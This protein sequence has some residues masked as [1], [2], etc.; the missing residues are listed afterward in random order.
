MSDVS[1]TYTPTEPFV[2]IKQTSVVLAIANALL[3]L[4]QIVAA[5]FS[6]S[7]AL[8][9]DAMHT[10]SDLIF[11]IITYFA[12]MYGSQPPDSTQPY[13]YRRIETMTAILLSFILLGLG[14]GILYTTWMQL[15]AP[16]DV[17]SDYVVFAALASIITNEALYRYAA[18][19]AELI[20]SQLLLASATHQRT[21][22][23]SSVVV[24]LTAALDI[25]G[26]SLNMD[27]YGALFIGCM[28]V[29]MGFSI[30]IEG[31]RELM[32][33]GIDAE[34]INKIKETINADKNVVG[35][36]LLR[37]RKMAGDIYIDVHIITDSYISVS[38]GHFIGERIRHTLQREYPHIA[39][40]TVHIDPEDDEAYHDQPITL[41]DRAQ[42]IEQL[43]AHGV[44]LQAA[45]SATRASLLTVDRLV[46]HY[47]KQRLC[48][49]LYIDSTSQIKNID[50]MLDK[51][52]SELKSEHEYYQQ[53]RVFTLA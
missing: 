18:S 49:D 15:E 3:A 36:H 13:G 33:A 32:D 10:F 14:F 35:V 22:A 19:Q 20:N 41:P 24:L 7:H 16:I 42:V 44:V 27:Y 9:A 51:L 23:L 46:I 38:E 53:V 11:D 1:K 50:K 43:A 29:K 25:A 12:G 2:V 6:S 34:Q 52:L 39:D 4:L 28:I 47:I 21:D 40:V 26:V 8:F 17:K 45:K 37:S 31:L 30:S 48:V 5:W